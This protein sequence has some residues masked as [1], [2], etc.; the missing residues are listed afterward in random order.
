[1]E[2]IFLSIYL[3]FKTCTVTLRGFAL[4]GLHF[5]A[6]RRKRER[7]K[8]WKLLI[9]FVNGGELWILENFRSLCTCMQILN[10]HFRA[11]TFLSHIKSINFHI[12]LPDTI[13]NLTV[14]HFVW[15][16]MMLMFH[17]SRLWLK[18][19]LGVSRSLWSRS[20]KEEREKE[21]EKCYKFWEHEIWRW[22]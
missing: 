21:S 8:L 20:G 2:V 19:R 11:T 15:A 12:A 14:V 7:R 1:M 22:R 9:P 3:P 5:T 6:K 16:G 4:D 18:R 13:L 10:T 17:P